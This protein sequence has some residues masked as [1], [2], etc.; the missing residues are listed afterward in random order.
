MTRRKKQD[1]WLDIG[2]AARIESP[3][4]LPSLNSSI[5][6][7]IGKMIAA[8]RPWMCDGEYIFLR[9]KVANP[10]TLS[11]HANFL[12]QGFH[13]H[14]GTFDEVEVWEL[15]EGSPF[16]SKEPAS[17]LEVSFAE[18]RRQTVLAACKRDWSRYVDGLEELAGR[19]K[20][21][22]DAAMA[23]TMFTET[24][25]AIENSVA[26]RGGPN[27]AERDREVIALRKRR[28]HGRGRQILLMS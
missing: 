2:D 15:L 9:R 25:D 7:R 28:G 1:D 17:L 8:Q 3:V 4:K 14:L 21:S 11:R 10:H 18:V 19:L 27:R 20:G 6:Q 13:K 12:A 22:Y 24:L 5:G 23:K 26:I 16:K